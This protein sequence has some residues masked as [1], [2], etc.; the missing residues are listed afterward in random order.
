M[1]EDCHKLIA[2]FHKVR[3]HFSKISK[4]SMRFDVMKIK[5]ANTAPNKNI[6]IDLSTVHVTKVCTL[7][8]DFLIMNK[9]LQCC[10][11]DYEILASS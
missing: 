10:T 7:S 3:K 9:G 8:S 5:H 6:A 2:K 11:M 1:L 4:S